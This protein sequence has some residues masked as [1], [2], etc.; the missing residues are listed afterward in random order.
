[1]LT[2]SLAFEYQV[3]Q[4]AA[5]ISFAHTLFAEDEASYSD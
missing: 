5:A 4:A 1:L 3:G 2:T